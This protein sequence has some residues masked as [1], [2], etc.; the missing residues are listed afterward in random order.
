MVA[1]DAYT[2]VGSVVGMLL[3]IGKGS[4]TGYSSIDCSCITEHNGWEG[5]T[6]DAPSDVAATID[7]KDE[8]TDEAQLVILGVAAMELQVMHR[9]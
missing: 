7:S 2:L 1:Q 3:H 5:I 9:A 6:T 8:A 4:N